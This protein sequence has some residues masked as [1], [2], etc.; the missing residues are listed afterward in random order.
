MIPF[1]F[2]DDYRSAILPSLILIVGGILWGQ[3]WILS[4]S[5]AARGETGPMIRFFA[6]NVL[7]MAALDL[8]LIPVL[9]VVGAALASVGGSMAGLAL[10]LATYRKRSPDLRLG[11]LI[12]TRRDAE[13]LLSYFRTLV[14]TTR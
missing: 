14:S 7:V 1:A 12:P 4:R 9:G 6:A 2:G 13:D 11:A 8:L 3:Q 10:C 5:L